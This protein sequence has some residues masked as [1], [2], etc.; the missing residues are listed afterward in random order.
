ME[1]ITSYGILKSITLDNLTVKKQ[2][3][4]FYKTLFA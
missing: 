2:S 1:N 4:E 3:F